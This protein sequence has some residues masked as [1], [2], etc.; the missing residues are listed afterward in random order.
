MRL[1]ETTSKAVSGYSTVL[2]IGQIEVALWHDSLDGLQQAYEKLTKKTFH[3][4]LS[5][6]TALMHLTDNKP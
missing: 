5:Q 3:L 4:A 1:K 6:K 2:V